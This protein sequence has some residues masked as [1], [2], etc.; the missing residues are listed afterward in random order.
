MKLNPDCI[1]EILLYV[2]DCTTLKNHVTFTDDNVADIF[3]SYSS[4]EIFYHIKQCDLS[5]FFER[6]SH[7]LDG[8][9]TV[10]YLS[11]AGHEFIAYL[12]ND[13]FFAKVKDI[14]KDIGI[15]TLKGLAQIASASLSTLIKQHFNLL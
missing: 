11:P 3:P 6:T 7:N 15:T 4:A 8:D 13:A 9:I 2:E 10:S 5:G 1:R 14:G 12:R